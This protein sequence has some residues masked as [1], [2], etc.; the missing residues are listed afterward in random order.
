MN[1]TKK[2]ISLTELQDGQSGV[3]VSLNGGKNLIKRLA[4]LG[5]RPGMI[6]TVLRTSLFTGPVQVEVSG[7]RLVLGRGMAA[8]IFVEPK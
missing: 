1:N 7:S 6:I 8:K 2:E 5:I 3:I 4:D